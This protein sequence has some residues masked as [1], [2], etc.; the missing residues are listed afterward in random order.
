M[1]LKTLAMEAGFHVAQCLATWALDSLHV[2][3]QSLYA[4]C[5]H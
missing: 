2:R 1:T 5:S 4:F 3:N